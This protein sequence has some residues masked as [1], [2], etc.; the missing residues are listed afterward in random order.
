MT[1][2]ERQLTQD[3]LSE[4]S[5]ESEL[6]E[7]NKFLV[8]LL[9]SPSVENGTD[10]ETFTVSSLSEFFVI[11]I[12][13]LPRSVLKGKN[14]SLKIENAYD[15]TFI[16]PD[17]YSR[18]LTN[19]EELQK[20]RFEDIVDI[21]VHLR[22]VNFAINTERYLEPSYYYRNLDEITQS[23][24]LQNLPFRITLHSDFGSSQ[25]ELSSDGVTPET[26]EYLNQSGV[27]DMKN[28]INSDIFIAANECKETIML[29]YRNVCE[30]NLENPL[31]ELIQMANAD[32]LVLSKSSFAFV[33]GVLNSRGRV[34]SPIYWNRPLKSW[35]S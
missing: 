28:N 24:Y 34:I 3:L 20:P 7:I 9:N 23:L 8:S 22:F 15:F 25:P 16:D 33:A 5:Q 4:K 31:A 1:R 11:L 14:I 32:F 21:R 35:N 30:D 2:V 12:K 6:V 13:R 29:R 19:R 27:I 10:R 17:L 18:G 26:L